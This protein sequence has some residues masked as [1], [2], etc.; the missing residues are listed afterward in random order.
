MSLKRKV[1]IMLGVIIVAAMTFGLISPVQAATGGEVEDPCITSVNGAGGVLATDKS[2]RV[3]SGD[4]VTIDS[5]LVGAGHIVCVQGMTAQGGAANNHDGT[6]SYYPNFGTTGTDSFTVGATDG[7]KYYSTVVTVEIE[8]VMLPK[9]KLVKKLVVKKGKVVR[10]AVV[11]FNNTSSRAG[12]V[13]FGAS[14]EEEPDGQRTIQAGGLKK[15]K[16]KRVRFDFVMSVLNDEGF[17]VLIGIGRVNTK[18][19]KVKM[20]NLA[21]PARMGVLS[22]QAPWKM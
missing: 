8:T 18:T 12:M 2:A 9:P 22:R 6:V 21:M 19:G 11:R 5:L 3:I 7:D 16:T 20:E 17:P 14:T 4:A 1:I 15:V 13:M 10:K